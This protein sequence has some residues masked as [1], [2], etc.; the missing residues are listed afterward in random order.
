MFSKMKVAVLAVF[1]ICIHNH[2]EPEAELAPFRSGSK[3][4]NNKKHFKKN[5]NEKLN[6]YGK[7]RKIQEP[8]LFLLF[9]AWIW[10]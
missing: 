5:S 6:K 2:A 9:I 3:T 10:V 4:L 7:S 1:H 8:V